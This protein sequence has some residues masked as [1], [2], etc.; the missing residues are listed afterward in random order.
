[1]S[2]QVPEMLQ[3]SVTFSTQNKNWI[4]TSGTVEIEITS[5]LHN[6]LCSQSAEMKQSRLRCSALMQVSVTFSV[7]ILSVGM[8][9]SA[10]LC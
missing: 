4:Y 9:L 7:C 1:M 2:I 8:F 6:S 10:V 3:L 5:L